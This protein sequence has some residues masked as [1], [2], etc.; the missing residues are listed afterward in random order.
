MR[1]PLVPAEGVPGVALAERGPEG[2]RPV[3]RACLAA[4]LVTSYTSV[5]YGTGPTCMCTVAI[6]NGSHRNMHVHNCHRQRQLQEHGLAPRTCPEHHMYISVCECSGCEQADTQQA[7]GM[8]AGDGSNAVHPNPPSC[9]IHFSTILSAAMSSATNERKRTSLPRSNRY[10][11]TQARTRFM[12]SAIM[13]FFT[14]RSRG[15]SA[16]SAGH[17]LTSISHARS[18]S[19]SMMSNPHTW[20]QAVQ[21]SMQGACCT[22][23]FGCERI[24]LH[25][26]QEQ[27]NRGQ[28]GR[29]WVD[30]MLM[31][32]SHLEADVA[33][34]HLHLDFR[35][36]ARLS[37]DDGGRDDV[38]HLLA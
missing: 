21:H 33:V 34:R 29:G 28:Q 10:P 12:T 38:V 32:S 8:M 24:W 1:V 15:E 9:C 25:T 17:V 37:G 16:A 14:R 31:L 26:G 6:N 36:D 23:M 27:A 18:A 7:G 11:A 2:A 13:L 4:S 22:Y 20:Q 5:S 35:V 3:R 30:H 19:S